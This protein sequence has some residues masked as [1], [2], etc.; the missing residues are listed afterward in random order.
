MQPVPGTPPAAMHGQAA[1]LSVTVQIIIN[2]PTNGARVELQ[3]S[4]QTY[5][6]RIAR[7][8][9][10][11]EISRRPPGVMFPEVTG[12]S[13]VRARQALDK[14]GMRAKPGK[15]ETAALIGLPIMGGSTGVFGS[16]LHSFWQISAFAASAFIGAVCVI[17]TIAR[18]LQ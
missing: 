16:Y 12:S 9:E 7:E 14:H 1:S 3:N 2:S 6:D 13:V 18:R 10:T 4:V 8:S 15:M 5:A 11:Q 17:Y